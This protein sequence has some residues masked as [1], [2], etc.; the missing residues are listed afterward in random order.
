MMAKTLTVQQIESK[1]YVIRGKKV[2]FDRDL[3][4]LYEVTTGNLNKAVQRNIERFPADFMF[5]LNSEEYES[6]R[7]QIG[8]L[9][10]GQHSKYFPY[11][12]TQEGVAML[13]GVLRSKRAV[14]VNIQIMRAFVKLRQLLMSNHDLWHK[15][16]EMEKKYDN[17]FKIVF[18]ALRSLLLSG[19]D[20]P[21]TIK[22]F[23]RE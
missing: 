7:F 15:I 6:L 5:Q 4:E 1:I 3:A 19:P 9:K 20:K 11:A 10:R 22:G 17:N 2:M 8:I 12:F 13:S 23:T 14:L 18:D 16:E 21:L